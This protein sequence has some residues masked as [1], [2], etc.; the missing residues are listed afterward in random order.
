MEPSAVGIRRTLYD[1]TSACS[2]PFRS[3][4]DVR[5]RSCDD[6]T[7]M[8]TFDSSTVRSARRVPVTM[9]WSR[10]C[11]VL[12][13]PASTVVVTTAEAESS[14]SA[15]NAWPE[16]AAETAAANVSG[17]EETRFEAMTVTDPGWLLVER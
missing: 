8:G 11:S 10:G 13:E 6:T 12:T 1:G 16:S 3:D 9:T 14:E 5:W 15:A 4:V 17:D 2:L 7:S